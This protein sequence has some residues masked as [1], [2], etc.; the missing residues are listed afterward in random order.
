[1]SPARHGVTVRPADV[2]KVGV[3]VTA[4]TGA[5]YCRVPM[6]LVGKVRRDVIGANPRR[7]VSICMKHMNNVSKILENN[8]TTVKFFF[9]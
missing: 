2:T 1:M 6:T 4:S 3:A 5:I 8:L 9:S 7:R